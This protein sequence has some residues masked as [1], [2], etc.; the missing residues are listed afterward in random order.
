MLHSLY[1]FKAG[2]ATLQSVVQGRNVKAID[3]WENSSK[4][5]SVRLTTSV[6]RYI[7]KGNSIKYSSCWEADSRLSSQKIY[8]YLRIL[9]TTAY[10][11]TLSYILTFPWRLTVEL[12]SRLYL[13][14][15]ILSR[16]LK[17]KSFVLCGTFSP[18]LIIII[19]SLIVIVLLH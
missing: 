10:V 5:K 18:K 2:F 15:S 1:S 7:L 19:S 16:R 17:F 4:K 14:L 13:S 12:Y 9:H 11:Y 8:P 6:G 3:F